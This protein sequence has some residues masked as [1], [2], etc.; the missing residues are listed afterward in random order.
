M[1]FLRDWCDIKDQ[2]CQYL[3]QINF[4][5]KPKQ[6]KLSDI[7]YDYYD[8][9]ERHIGIGRREYLLILGTVLSS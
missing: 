6:D 1:S 2:K 9:E 7:V 3:R 5:V 8:S 4:Q